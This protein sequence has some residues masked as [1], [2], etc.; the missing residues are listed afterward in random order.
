MRQFYTIL[1]PDEMRKTRQYMSP[2]EPVDSCLLRSRLWRWWEVANGNFSITPP[3]LFATYNMVS[4]TRRAN[5][6]KVRL[7]R[8]EVSQLDGLMNGNEL[9]MLSLLQPTDNLAFFYRYYR[10]FRH[11]YE[12]VEAAGIFKRIPHL[13]DIPF[14]PHRYEDKEYQENAKFSG[15]SIYLH[16]P[17]IW[18]HRAFL[19]WIACYLMICLS[20]D[21]PILE[22]VCHK[23]Y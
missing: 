10:P 17:Y 21:T 7:L 14:S 6:F 5:F 3:S 9:K 15:H 11:T 23:F 18:M 2:E 22:A 19:E 1:L 20:C 12:E 8:G 4:P 13:R 16:K